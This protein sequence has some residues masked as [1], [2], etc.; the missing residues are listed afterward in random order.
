[1]HGIG[2]MP[3]EEAPEEFNRLTLDFL[4]RGDSLVE[5]AKARIR[6]DGNLEAGLEG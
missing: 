6:P 4:D 2:H 1:M 3:Y 5:P